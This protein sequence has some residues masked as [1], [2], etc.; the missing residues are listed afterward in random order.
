MSLKLGTKVGPYIIQTHLGSGAFGDVYKA[1]HHVFGGEVAVKIL[2]LDL[3]RDNTAELRF[4]REA[5]ILGKLRHEY[6][7]EVKDVDIDATLKVAWMSMSLMAGPLR[8]WR[9][10]SKRPQAFISDLRQLTAALDYIHSQ[11]VIHR[12]LKPANVLQDTTGKLRI[13]DFGIAKIAGATKLTATNTMLGTCCYMAPEQINGSGN[14]DHRCDIY[15]LGVMVFE[16]M[17]GRPPFEGDTMEVLAAHIAA[18]VPLDLLYLQSS[19]TKKVMSKALEK[20]ASDRW[21]SAG[22]FCD[23]LEAALIPSLHATKALPSVDQGNG[24][25][26]SDPDL[27]PSKARFF[28]V[29]IFASILA[30]GIA[31]VAIASLATRGAEIGARKTGVEA[32]KPGEAG[33]YAAEAG[34][35][36]IEP[37]I[38]RSDILNTAVVSDADRFVWQE[39]DL[40]DKRFQVIL[41]H[42]SDDSEKSW[43][44][45]DEACNRMPGN[46]WKLPPLLYLRILGIDRLVDAHL[47]SSDVHQESS[48][49]WTFRSWK[50]GWSTSIRAES[51]DEVAQSI[52]VRVNAASLK[53]V[54][55]DIFGGAWSVRNGASRFVV[56]EEAQEIR[57]I[58]IGN[59]FFAPGRNNSAWMDADW[60]SSKHVC[61][62]SGQGWRL[63][64]AIE[65][66][67]L[68]SSDSEA[69][70]GVLDPTALSYWTDDSDDSDPSRRGIVLTSGVVGFADRDQSSRRRFICVK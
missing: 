18:P 26:K 47:W 53:G 67:D 3:I 52:C 58:A 59:T 30:C 17:A 4:M 49:A 39:N 9:L 5:K 60:D 36:R 44:K 1:K 22:E 31:A 16:A 43:Y 13:A 29:L 35:A 42:A 61:Q 40:V 38:S 56:D 28:K 41:R 27:Q 14:I 33:N 68:V 11:K 37:S 7:I 64:L 70:V 19:E 24:D 69:V 25:Q 54:G 10:D 34:E 45:A 23:A 8:N 15:S 50:I 32:G 51:M 62:S 46:E 48:T 20:N 57:D 12:D 66:M 21:L 2:S 63:P 55:A 6:L 65:L